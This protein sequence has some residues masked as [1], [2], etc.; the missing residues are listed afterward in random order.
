[1]LDKIDS[2]GTPILRTVVLR[3]GSPNPCQRS[4]SEGPRRSPTNASWTYRDSIFDIGHLPYQKP[5]NAKNANREGGAS[6]VFGPLN[7]YVPLVKGPK[8]AVSGG[9]MVDLGVKNKRRATFVI[10]VFAT[11]RFFVG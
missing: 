10:G 6:F 9:K 11:F 5:E 4:V 3:G 8:K 1:M 2:P 7:R